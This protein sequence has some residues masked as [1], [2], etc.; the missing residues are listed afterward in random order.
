MVSLQLWSR[1]L[2]AALRSKSNQEFYDRIAPIYDQCFVMHK[3]HAINMA[4]VLHD[5][6]KGQE[7]N[8]LVLDLGCGTGLL[9]DILA[10]QGF[11]VIAVDISLESLRVSRK[12]ESKLYPIQANAMLLP[13]VQESC[14]AVVS[15]GAW[16]H[17][18]DPRQVIEEVARILK[19]D[20]ALILGY[21]PP[22]IGGVIQPGNGLWSRLLVRVYQFV[23]RKRGYMDNVDLSL[24]SR[25]L[26]LV[27]KYFMEVGTVDSGKCWH[28]IVAR[29][30]RY[31]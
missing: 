25:T 13:F 8:T 15:L 16:R 18:S 29:G 3:L 1:V 21:F 11:K 27:K 7:N 2:L 19:K 24:E 31:A 6:Y 23:I 4:A 9:G 12:R 20:G 28:L 10:G 30:L 14:S 26:R 5:G 22:A 17:F